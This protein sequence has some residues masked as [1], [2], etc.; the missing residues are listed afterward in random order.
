MTLP[1]KRFL[2]ILI[3][4]SLGMAS[5]FFGLLL[6]Q[7]RA[8]H[9][10][11][12]REGG[13]SCGN[14][15]YPIWLTTGELLAHRTTNPYSTTMEREI[16]I[17]LYGR[18]LDR[19]VRQDA[20]INYRGFSYPLYTD[21]LAI[22]FALLSFDTVQVILFI[23]FPLLIVLS[24]RW[25]C[26]AVGLSLS[27]IAFAIAALLTLFTIQVLEGWWAL[28][29]TIIVGAL[30]AITLAALRR[31]ALKLA[32]VAL[33]LGS[34]KPQLILLPALWL[35]LW[36]FS[37]W[38]RRR[39]AFLALAVTMIVLLALSELWIPKWWLDWWHQLPAYRQFDSPPLVE[40]MFG[41]VIGRAIGFAAVCLATIAAIRWRR[42]T[43]DSPCFLLLFAFLLATGVVFISSSIA[44]YDQF[45]LAPGILILWRD[46]ASAASDRLL[47]FAILVL[48]VAFCWPWV[49]APAVYLTH[50][51]APSVISQRV[52]ILPLITAASFPLLLLIVLG[53]LLLKQLREAAPQSDPVATA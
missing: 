25:W 24:V 46:R 44:V 11:E 3:F 33:A 49:V 51:I 20:A 29:P 16:E 47:R 15:L 38:T 31:D 4:L 40:L 6:P 30:L 37:D 39:R 48:S 26:V 53:M 41:K 23:S 18:P 10:L 12:H 14:D 36:S 9:R 42:L 43:A 27:P 52:M 1:P 7:V 28:Q 22:P 35:T 5:Y 2:T 8:I 32:G 13:Y 21:L 45:L 50:V 19:S 17:G 34:I